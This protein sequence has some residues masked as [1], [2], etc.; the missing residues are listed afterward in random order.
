MG[1]W[2]SLDQKH[3]NL[4]GETSRRIIVDWNITKEEWD[5]TTEE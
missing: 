4:K 1:L 5:A 3:I 2:S